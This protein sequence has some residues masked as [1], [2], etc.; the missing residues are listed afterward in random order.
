MGTGVEGFSNGQLPKELHMKPLECLE[1]NN[2]PSDCES[3]GGDRLG[4]ESTGFGW[5][6]ESGVFPCLLFPSLTTL[7]L[8]LWYIDP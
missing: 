1:E 6:K 5:T 8:H 7:P 4:L 3:K 2:R